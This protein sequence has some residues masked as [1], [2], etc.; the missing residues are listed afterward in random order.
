MFLN[1][2]R[3]SM[4]DIDIDFC[5]ER[6]SEVIDYVVQKYGADHVAQII[7]FGTMAA[8]AAIRDVGRAL[9][10]PYGDVDR[11]AKLVPAELNITIEKAL[12]DAA[13]L[14]EL[15]D[16]RAEVKK[17]IDTASALEG[18]P[19]HAS[20]HAAGIVITPEP[21]THY[22]PLYKAS[23]GP[24]T[25]QFSMGTVEELGLLKMDML[26]LRTLTV[27]SD[28]IKAIAESTGH[29]LDIDKIPIDDKLTY[30]MLSRGEAAGVFQL[31][32]SGMR[33]ILK[34]LKPE[35]F[36]DIVAL[37]AL[38]RPGPLGSGMVEDFIKN[39]HGIKKTNYLHPKLEPILKDTY[40]VILYQ[41]QVMRISSELAGF[42]LGEADM[43]RRAMGKKKPE[44]IAGL[45]TQFVEGAVKNGVDEDIAGQIFDL[46]EFFAGYGFNKCLTGDTK[47]VNYDGRIKTIKEIYETNDFCTVL[48]LDENLKLVEGKISA[49]HENGL[50]DVYRLRTRTGRIIKATSNHKFLSFQGWKP[51]KSFNKGEHV[52]VP[53]CLPLQSAKSMSEHEL[54]VLAYVLSE[55]NTCHPHTF[56]YYTNSKEELDDYLHYLSQ[57]RNARATVVERRDKYEVHVCNVKKGVKQFNEA[58]QFIINMGLQ[59]KKAVDK[60]IPEEIFELNNNDIAFFLGKLW[61]GDGCIDTRN[62][63]TYYATSSE[64]LA[65]QIQHLLLRISIKSTVH[66]KSF[67]YRDSIRKGFTV[68]VTGYDSLQRFI[69]S[70][71]CCF[72]GQREA[73]LT[74]LVVNHPYIN[75]SLPMT[76][77]R[78][79]N[80]L[81]PYEIFS[82][83]RKEIER[84]QGQKSLKDI[85]RQIGISERNFWAVS[86]KI[87]KGYRRETLQHVA[88]YLQ[89]PE[90]SRLSYSDILWDEII[91]VEPAGREMTYDLTVD[92][93]HN[94][95]ANDIIVHN[96]H[97]AAYAL[98]TYQTA[99]LKANYKHQFM[100]ALLTSVKDNTDKVSAYIEECRRLGI[101]VLPP[102]VNES[103]ESFTVAGSKIR[104]GLAAVKNVGLGAVESII[105]SREK[106]GAFSDYSDFCRRLDTRVVNRR[107]LESLIKCGAFDSLGYRRAQLMAA[108]DSGLGLAQQSQRERE[109]GQ[110][111]LLDFLDGSRDSVS[112]ILP[113]VG[114]YPV[115]EMLALE[116]E[117]LGLYISGHPL[118]QYRGVLNMLATVT[119]V[120]V[121][122]LPDNSEIVLGGLITGIK[123]TSTRRGDPMAILT[124]EDLTGSIEVVVYP[125]PYAQSRLA[126]RIDEVVVVKGKSRENGEETKIIGEEI[127]TLDSQLEGELH[128]KIK[129]ANTP[130]LDQLQIIMSSFKGNSPV[131]LH[132]EDEK[133]VIKAGEEFYVDLSGQMIGRL[134][135]LLGKSRVKVKR[136]NNTLHT[137][138][139]QGKTHES[140]E[141]EN[142]VTIADK[143]V[144]DKQVKKNEFFSILE[145]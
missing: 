93:T 20:T 12:N 127:T 97:S 71:G 65:Y 94:F 58:K 100:A 110:L 47:I 102:D 35:V 129:S 19:R 117:T 107:V 74:K 18:M 82:L 6:R 33:A 130:L 122:E 66:I 78:G 92:G 95:V 59:W 43:L 25:T 77:A 60:F 124:V 63:Q 123:K 42:T 8:R 101:E 62:T 70:I 138:L 61:V 99:Y 7:T 118:S 72:V 131:F 51:L 113:E 115:D 26:G 31:E 41:E 69:D 17:L 139:D 37:V 86:K 40:G 30:E 142:A 121:P 54:A 132:F 24:V 67:K 126:L 2:E 105:R 76:F 39:K 4:P 133:K 98:V 50:K 83:L 73:D 128:L 68:N 15:Y 134:E 3:V 14:K 11:V 141:P 22:I 103:R 120:E 13:E 79:S 55:G 125:R 144:G 137:G 88:D 104:F 21:L 85:A 48:T 57:F 23:D 84:K 9:S 34:E 140:G 44:I 5:F 106:D 45:R 119:A 116:K 91:S 49:I 108:V 29:N 135:E 87:K 53:R 136:K 16:Q 114:E 90:L 96:S 10:M 52:A 27:I 46:M 32:S 109:N 64:T 143:K 80:D 38:Y 81:I 89:S 56:Y 28:A 36:E 111:S 1:P 145:L 75:N 112:I